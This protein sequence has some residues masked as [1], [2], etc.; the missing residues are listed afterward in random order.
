MRRAVSSLM[1]LVAFALVSWDTFYGPDQPQ[2]LAMLV[3][4]KSSANRFRLA[5]RIS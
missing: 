5:L 1:D 3:G 4:V 2:A